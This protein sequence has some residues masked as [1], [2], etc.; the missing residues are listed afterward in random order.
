MAQ[1]LKGLEMLAFKV[2]IDGKLIQVAGVADWSILALHI[3]ASRG[4]VDASESTARQE[5]TRYSVGGLSMP[6]ESD[7]RQHFRWQER[8]LAVGSTVSVQVIETD[9]PDPVVRRYRSDAIV[10]ESAF[11]DAEMRAMR[12]QDYL[13]LK[14]EFEEPSTSGASLE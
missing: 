2:E 11:T 7:I 13:A 14:R 3:T 9:S 6:D 1:I 5:S 10:R 12:F 8:E 4:E